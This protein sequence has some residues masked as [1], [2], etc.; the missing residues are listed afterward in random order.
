MRKEKTI[1]RWHKSKERKEEFQR[2]KYQV[3][4]VEE[5]E[6]CRKLNFS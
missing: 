6:S 3:N 2:I 1:K 4:K 5:K